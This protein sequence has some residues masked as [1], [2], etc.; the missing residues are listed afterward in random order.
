MKIDYFLSGDPR[1]RRKIDELKG[2]IECVS[3]EV[4]V[5]EERVSFWEVRHSEIVINGNKAIHLAL[6]YSPVTALKGLLIESPIECGPGRILIDRNESI[7]MIYYNI[8]LAKERG[9]EAVLL[10]KVRK[11]VS[12]SPPYLQDGPSLPPLPLAWINYPVKRGYHI[13]LNLDTRVRNSSSL[14]LHAIK[15]GNER[16]VLLVTKHDNWLSEDQTYFHVFNLFKKLNS[17]TNNQWELLSMSGTES[18]SPGFSSLFWN[19]VPR[20]LSPKF[21]DIS[22]IIELKRGNGEIRRSPGTKSA[23]LDQNLIEPSSISFEFLREGVP[24]VVYDINDN[25]LQSRDSF[26]H[27][28]KLIQKHSSLDFHFSFTQM[29]NDLIY[30]YIILPPEL[31]SILVNLENVNINELKPFFKLFGR[32]LYLPGTMKYALFHH[33]VSIR[34]SHLYEHVFA[35]GYPAFHI[36]RHES[37]NSSY[38]SE[39]DRAT[40]EKYMDTIYYMLHELL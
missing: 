6:P 22:L 27:I 30:D 24:S 11:A 17:K 23:H 29:I 31:K 35:E 20:I 32:Y 37:M 21:S 34:K 39:L 1:E 10:T 16:R 14:S 2:E 33:L 5:Y 38:I 19:Y 15:H 3:D 9:C 12:V 36:R 8:L 40:T 13:E 25:W 26:D 4:K 18:G 28:F 7:E